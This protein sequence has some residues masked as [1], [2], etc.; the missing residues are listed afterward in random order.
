[1]SFINKLGNYKI[2]LFSNS[3]LAFAIGLFTPFWI[4]FLQKFGGGVEQFGIAIGI[5]VFAQS[6]TSYFV[7]KYSDKLGRKVFLIAGGFILAAVVFSYTIIQ[8]LVELYILQVLNGVTNAMQ[9]TMETAFLGDV[10]KKTTRGLNIGK[11]HAIVGAIAGL[12]IMG[13]GYIVGGLGFNI[14]F[15]AVAIIIFISTLF[16]FFID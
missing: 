1:M 12:T 4:I 10:T 15:Y 14:I 11:Y 2:F 3:M 5:M 8:T 6:I 9:M 16:L 13:S 7:G